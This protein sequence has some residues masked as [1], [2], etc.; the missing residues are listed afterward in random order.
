LH[1]TGP[2]TTDAVAD[3][4]PAAGEPG[5]ALASPKPKLVEDRVADNTHG[6]KIPPAL[7]STRRA[8]AVLS[9]DAVS[10]EPQAAK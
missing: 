1:L 3:V 9:I 2:V 7:R 8:E 10:A 5:P 4:L 6:G